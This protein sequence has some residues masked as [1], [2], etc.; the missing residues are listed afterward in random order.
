MKNAIILFLLAASLSGCDI[1]NS[2]SIELTAK[3]EGQRPAGGNNQPV[4]EEDEKDDPN[5]RPEEQ[6]VTFD[7]LKRTSLA[8]CVRCHARSSNPDEKPFFRNR[9]EIIQHVDRVIGSIDEGSMPPPQ[10]TAK[11]LTTC[12]RAMLE[13]WVKSG[14]PARTNVLVHSIEECK[15]QEPVDPPPTEPPP[16]EPVE[17]PPVDP[18]LPEDLITFDFLLK[19]SFVSCEGCHKTTKNPKRKPIL[20]SIED[21]RQHLDKVKS[22]VMSDEMPS[23]DSG[24]QLLTACEKAMMNKWIDQGAPDKTDTRRS[25]LAECQTTSAL[26]EIK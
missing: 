17:P 9:S 2:D 5:T 8:S 1:K 4:L 18:G 10:S 3:P 24:D 15:P 25:E 26:V 22:T 21:Y 6:L 16:P 20:L 23:T 14:M 13:V 12:E 19:T 11:P 7:F